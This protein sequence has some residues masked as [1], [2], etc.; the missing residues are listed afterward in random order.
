MLEML[1]ALFGI[2]FFFFC[3]YHNVV[4]ASRSLIKCLP[5]TKRFV[6][7]IKL[8][9]NRYGKKIKQMTILIC[10]FFERIGKWKEQKKKMV[11]M[12][13]SHDTMNIFICRTISLFECPCV[14]YQFI[15]L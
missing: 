2:L 8:Q 3:M 4:R 11:L 12:F 9:I 15:M 5:L 14:A 13:K 10:A 6:I 7:M 1:S